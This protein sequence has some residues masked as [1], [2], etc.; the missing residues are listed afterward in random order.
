MV[1]VHPSASAT[2]I[3]QSYDSNQQDE[4]SAVKELSTMTHDV[5]TGAMS[6]TNLAS[7][8][9]AA[10]PST[11]SNDNGGTGVKGVYSGIDEDDENE[12]SDGNGNGEHHVQLERQVTETG[13]IV[14]NSY[15]D[16]ISK[17]RA[18]WD[19]VPDVIVD[20]KDL[21]YTL[22]LPNSDKYVLYCLHCLSYILLDRSLKTQ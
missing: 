20:M 19:D 5:V 13:E 7:M 15:L 21:S 4:L 22:S 11:E 8:D 2:S 6:S 12:N 9:R 3:T 10:T 18:Q 14:P 17:L 1:P 16:Y